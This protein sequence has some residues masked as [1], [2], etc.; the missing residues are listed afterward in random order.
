MEFDEGSP[1]REATPRAKL[2]SWPSGDMFPLLVPLEP[3]DD[4]EAM[5]AAL[6]G[7]L[8]RPIESLAEVTP[9]SEIPATDLIPTERFDRT[10]AGPLQQLEIML[11]GQL[12]ID[13]ALL[14]CHAGQQLTYGTASLFARTAAEAAVQLDSWYVASYDARTGR[15]GV[16]MRYGEHAARHAYAQVLEEL[17]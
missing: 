13:R 7:V 8:S 15:L 2:L 16:V 10:P 4:G 1:A 11:A 3:D 17:S 5:M 9:A 12:S 6:A 14:V